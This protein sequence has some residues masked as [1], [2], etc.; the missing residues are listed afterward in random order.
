MVPSQQMPATPAAWPRSLSGQL[1]RALPALPAARRR[2]EE[3]VHCRLA[4]AAALQEPLGRRPGFCPR[5]HQGRPAVG[6][7]QWRRR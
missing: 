3:V 2:G 6:R 7:L 4:A 5:T 1:R